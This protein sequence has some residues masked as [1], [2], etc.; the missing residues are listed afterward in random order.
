M[1]SAGPGSEIMKYVEYIHSQK[2]IAVFT[3]VAKK[4]MAVTFT[5]QTA[6]WGIIFI[7]VIERV[8]VWKRLA[9]GKPNGNTSYGIS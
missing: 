1:F 4:K 3:W 8:S 7:H 2:V 6:V 5:C 9:C